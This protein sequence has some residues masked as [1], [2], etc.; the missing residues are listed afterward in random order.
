[1]TT[2][3]QPRPAIARIPPYVAGKP[4]VPR[5]GLTTYKLSSNE[6]PYP[7]LPGVVKAADAAVRTMNRYPDMG[8]AALYDALAQ[9]MPSPV[10]ELNRAVAVSM[11]FGP[12]AGLE[13]IDALMSN[14]ALKEYHLL[15]SVRADFLAKLGRVDEARSELERAASLTRNERE[16]ALILDRAAAL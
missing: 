11:A 14:A 5:E 12:A 16:R 8:N 1:M 7:P 15:P 9:V 2:S 3:P 4:P 13:I 6:N 10:V